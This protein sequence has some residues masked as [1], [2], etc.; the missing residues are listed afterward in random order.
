M[1]LLVQGGNHLVTAT[2][3]AGVS[4]ATFYR[5]L[6]REPSLQAEL[7]QARALGESAAVRALFEGARD[8]WRC[9]AKWLELVAPQRWGHPLDPR[10]R[11]RRA[12]A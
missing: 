12:R 1:L 2:A 10:R 8:D 3:A 6:D 5:L 11:R 7:A 9:A 4:R